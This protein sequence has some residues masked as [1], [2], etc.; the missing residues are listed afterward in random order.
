[1]VIV[2]C[3]LMDAQYMS[4]SPSLDDNLLASIDQSLSTFHQNKDVIMTLGAQTGTKKMIDNWH[5]PKLELMES[6]S[7]SIH[8][9]GAL[10][11]WSADATEHAQMSKIKEPA[12]QTNNNNYDPQICCHLDQQEK[13]QRFVI[14][15]MLK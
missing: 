9:V 5:I 14:A 12:Q 10:I 7:A 15:M 4:Q 6:I 11:Q 2:I 13:L 8:K 3:A 1:F